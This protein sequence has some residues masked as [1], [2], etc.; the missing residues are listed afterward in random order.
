MIGEVEGVAVGKKEVVMSLP[1]HAMIGGRNHR[2]DETT[3]GVEEEVA[4]VVQEEG[5]EVAGKKV[6]LKRL[7]GPSPLQGMN[8][9]NTNC[10]VQAILALILTNMRTFPWRRRETMYQITSPV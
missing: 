10:L 2:V 8:T 9:L 7:I 5:E 3:V 1:H 6:I 4:A